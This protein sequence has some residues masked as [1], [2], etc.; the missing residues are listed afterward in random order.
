MAATIR[1]DAPYK[2]FAKRL[3]ALRTEAGLTR[4][5]LGE[6]IGVAGRSIVN[7]ENGERIPYGD[8]CA[9]MAEV[10]GITTDELLGLENSELVMARE[11]AV[12]RMYSINGRSGA[13]RLR[14]VYA[15]AASLAGGDL[16]D[17]QL[18]EFSLE[19][20]KMAMLAQQRLRERHSSKKYQATVSEKAVQ[21]DMAVKAIDD[22]IVTM[23]ASREGKHGR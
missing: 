1:D 22:A 18:L 7:Y 21:T 14:Q 4:A 3:T 17:E 2:D 11:E 6:R 8:V 10:F 12:A 9:K 15:D 16:S 23:N 13:D 19:M 5:E 20:S